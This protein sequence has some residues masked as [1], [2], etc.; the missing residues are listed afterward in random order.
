M[1]FRGIEIALVLWSWVRVAGPSRVLFFH[2]VW[3]SDDGD[4]A[5][6]GIFHV[7]CYFLHFPVEMMTYDLVNGHAAWRI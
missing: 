5:G 6:G 1:R 7:C 3:K 2:V 4:G